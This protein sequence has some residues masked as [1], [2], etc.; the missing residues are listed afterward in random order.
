MKTSAELLEQITPEERAECL[1]L[2][3][4]GRSRIPGW[5]YLDALR[6]PGWNFSDAMVAHDALCDRVEHYPKEAPMKSLQIGDEDFGL[7]HDQKVVQQSRI[8]L[9]VKSDGTWWIVVEGHDQRLR[10][11]GF[12]RPPQ[13]QRARV[14]Y[15]DLSEQHV[16]EAF[17]AGRDS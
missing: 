1:R 3:P 5:R 11:L 2:S 16:L 10:T 17:L 15:D 4:P 14:T 12:V 8:W 6:K 7:I 13:E 9:T